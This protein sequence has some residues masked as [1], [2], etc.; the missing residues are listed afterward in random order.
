V[1]VL[2][3]SP[4]ETRSS[5]LVDAEYH[6]DPDR[7][8]SDI[9]EFI[10]AARELAVQSPELDVVLR[11][12]PRLMPNKRESVSSPD[13]EAIL[14]SLQDLPANAHINGP[15]DGISLYDLIGIASAALNQ[16][17]SSGLEYLS[18]GLPVVSYDP[19][20]QNAYPPE[21]G[22]CVDRFDP[23]SLADAVRGAVATGRSADHS[24]NAFRW[25]ATALLRDQLPL[26]N[27][28]EVAAEPTDSVPPT[29]DATPASDGVETGASTSP[30]VVTRLK[31]LVPVAAR[32]RA[33]RAMA[34][35]G[36]ADTIPAASDDDVWAAEWLLRLDA[37]EGRQV[38]W[39]PPIIVRGEPDDEHERT[40]IE[41]VVNDLTVALGFIPGMGFGPVAEP[42]SR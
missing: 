10:T 23:R 18:L 42:F 32:E 24:V 8:Y 26:S 19:V 28:W 2:L 29:T 1:V 31:E 27:V 20:R 9:A 41:A 4:D 37:T 34:R 39:T 36:R 38:V 6:R 5:M 30:G 25:Y 7:G 13:L 14:T 17:S 11:L 22:P 15:G 21:F 35:R 16:S 40:S 12:H 3:S 33:A